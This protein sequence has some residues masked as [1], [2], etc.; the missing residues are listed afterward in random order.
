MFFISRNDIEKNFKNFKN[1]I[2]NIEKLF[3]KM[4]NLAKIQ[5]QTSAILDVPIHNY[6][7][8]FTFIVN[9]EEIHTPKIISDLLSPKISENHISDPT[10]ETFTINTRNKGHFSTILS[11][12]TFQ[13]K[14]IPADELPFVSE[15]LEILQNKHFNVILPKRR[16][17]IKFDN[18]FE[19]IKEHENNEVLYKQYLDEEIDFLSENFFQLNEEQEERIRELTFC[20]IERILSNFD[21]LQLV[22]ENQLLRVVNG[23]YKSDSKYSVLYKYVVF[24]F[25][26]EHE[27]SE[28]VEFFDISDIDG[29]VWLS[30]AERLKQKVFLRET[31]SALKRFKHFG[32]VFYCKHDEAFD[33][34]IRHLQKESNGNIK[35][36]I[37]I[38]SSSLHGSSWSPYNVCLFEDKDKDKYFH[39]KD[40]QNSWILFDF[41]ER[42]IIPSNYIIK[43]SPY[44]Q[45]GNNPKTWKLEGSNDKSS[46]EP[47]DE[48]RDCPYFNGQYL[49][50]TFDIKKRVTTP[51]RYI[52]MTQTGPNWQD[53]RYHYFTLGSIEFYG[54]LI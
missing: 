4:S 22:D 21:K 27:M 51:F 32:T 6:E 19:L 26:D 45:N 43:S 36:V 1:F 37:D 53:N 40:E 2:L 14:T 39:T 3:C 47:L 5:L 11:L 15:V 24:T 8:T 48:Q 25:V 28:F 10:T 18:I 20:T 23:L 13:E 7:K 30:L 9:G 16:E 49:V 31:H 52:R 34:I 44:G 41:K 29:G 42:K 12:L 35:S 50:H 33:G 46:W 38:T 54:S 17:E